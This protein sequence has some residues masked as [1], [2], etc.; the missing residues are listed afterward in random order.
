MRTATRAALA[1]SALFVPAHSFIYKI[2]N[3]L[4]VT[5]HA[6][7]SEG[8]MYGSNDG[9]KGAPQGESYVDVDLEV[10]VI[11]LR[12]SSKGI[13]VNIIFYRSHVLDFGIEDNLNVCPESPYYP[14]SFLDVEKIPFPAVVATENGQNSDHYTAKVTAHRD[15]SESGLQHAFI[16]VCPAEMGTSTL[17]INGDLT[18]KNPYGYLPGM[19][20]GCLPF[21][22]FRF[23]ASIALGA[24]FSSAMWRHR[25]TLL[26]VHKMIFGVVVLGT[27]ESL[28]WLAAYSY[29]NST[30]KPYCCPYPGT[31][32]LAMIMEVLRRTTSRFMLLMICLG[33]GITR[34]QLEKREM[35]S[36]VTLTAIFLVSA[37]F[38]QLASSVGS[39][40]HVR[41]GQHYGEYDSM[42]AVPALLT[43][44]VFLMWIYGTLANMIKELRELNETYKLKMFKSLAWTL[45][46]F[47]TLFT[48]L[49]VAMLAAEGSQ[50]QS[51]QWKWE[52][53]QVVSWE[54]LNFCML[55]AVSIIWR[56]SERSAMLAY[57]KQV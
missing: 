52:W 11:P 37:G 44:M 4:N 3:T 14:S 34:V 43:D 40:S 20:F 6:S 54:I 56:P 12:K 55:V 28:S 21:E 33:Y 17:T 22:L 51:W 53:V 15:V 50:E 36:V 7:Y 25:A 24:L 31:V 16:Q 42:L 13:D 9:P 19:D 29:M 32:I 38:V 49:T 8:W 57:S 30:G 35:I 23:L 39:A 5:S 10:T 48:V 18:F 45:G 27:V 26:P 1:A 2:D 46:T 41:N 47:V